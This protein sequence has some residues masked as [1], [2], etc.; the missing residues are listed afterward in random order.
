MLDLQGL[1]FS[2]L[3]IPRK[4][5]L[6][7]L[8]PVSRATKSVVKRSIM[9]VFQREDLPKD[10]VFPANLK[11][12]GYFIND[13]DEIRMISNP[14]E[15]FLYKIN[16]NERYNEL[17]KEAMNTCIRNIVLSRLHD[18]GL[19]TLR[20][21]LGAK[22]NEQHVPI[23]VSPT[24]KTDERI[25]AVF[26][27]PVQDLGIWA[28]RII[29][30]E[31]INSGSAV[32]FSAAVLREKGESPTPGL[33][34]TNPGQLVWHCAGEKAIS[35]PSWLALPRKHA[36]EPP[37]KMTVRNKIPGHETWQDHVTYVF[38][39]VL[40][41]LAP[42]AKIDIIGL[43]EGSLAAVRYLAEHWSTWKSCISSMALGNPLHDMNHLHP[44]EFA[45]FISTRCRAYLIS[46]KELGQ[47]VAGRY[48]YSCNCYSS[49]ESKNVECIIPRAYESMLKWLDDMHDKPE[50]KETEVFVSEDFGSAESG[51]EF[52]DSNGNGAI[53]E[54]LN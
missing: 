35:L 24:F 4:L 47:P 49:G 38:D 40:G 19:E 2:L 46:D 36:V 33:I 25:I 52:G 8:Q 51:E 7:L 12:L 34:L 41:K 50:L 10:P 6:A 9:F 26:G 44:T 43:A 27:E 14:E 21:P 28:Y 3:H 29:G 13:K 32:D 11:Q 22:A 31:T 15:K 53:V 39:E 16:A 42:D 37:M 48:E 30:H 54:E 20:L 1:C 18:Q 45:E 17:Q 23:L 5:H